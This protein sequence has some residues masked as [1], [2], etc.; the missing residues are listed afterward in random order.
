MGIK[1]F[2]LRLTDEQHQ[3]LEKRSNEL[4]ITKNDYIR[5]LIMNDSFVDKQEKMMDEIS[6]IK[7][8]LKNLEK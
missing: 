6:E 4:G 5:N 2:T 1:T 3:Y 7:E 8:M